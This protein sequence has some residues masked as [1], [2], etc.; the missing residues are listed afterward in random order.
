MSETIKWSTC[1]RQVGIQGPSNGHRQT[2]LRALIARTAGIEYPKCRTFFGHFL[3]VGGFAIMH[4][5][6]SPLARMAVPI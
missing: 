2:K 1:A 5:G 6:K 4:D 3:R